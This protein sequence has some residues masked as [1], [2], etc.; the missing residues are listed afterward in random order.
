MSFIL[1]SY[2]VTVHSYRK[3]NKKTKKKKKDFWIFGEKTKRGNF[4]KE[5]GTY[6]L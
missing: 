3:K 6:H 5:E 2:F 4:S 1:V